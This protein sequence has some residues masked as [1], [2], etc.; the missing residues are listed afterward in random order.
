MLLISTFSLLNV[1][2]KV[3][4]AVVDSGGKGT[5][6]GSLGESGGSAWSRARRFVAP[7]SSQM[8]RTKSSSDTL[9]IG[10]SD[11]DETRTVGHVNGH[12]RGGMSTLGST[13]SANRNMD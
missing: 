6:G 10:G 12:Y 7:Q 1:V 3:A 2:L 4:A 8:S 13:R 11:T 5:T 9:A